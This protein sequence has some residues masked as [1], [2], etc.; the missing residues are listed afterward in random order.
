M[1]PDVCLHLKDEYTA[2]II[3]SL[4]DREEVQTLFVVCGLGQSRSVPHYMSESPK[5][6]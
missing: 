5:N 6:L 1:F 2:A 3:K 4:C